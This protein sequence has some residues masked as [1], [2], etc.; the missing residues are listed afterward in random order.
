MSA[1]R[2]GWL[3]GYSAVFFWTGVAMT[4]LCLGL[5]LASN[6][7]PFYR[8]DHASVPVPWILGGLAIISFVAAEHCHRAETRRKGLDESR[9]RRDREPEVISFY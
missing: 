2:R 3:T 5:I 7:E 8:L 9:A 1:N 6:T 4:L